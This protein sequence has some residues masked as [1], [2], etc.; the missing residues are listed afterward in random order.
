MPKHENLLS[1]EKIH[2]IA[3]YVYSLSHKPAP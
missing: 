1:D 3:A 2:V